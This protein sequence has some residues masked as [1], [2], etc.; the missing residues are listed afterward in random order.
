MANFFDLMGQA[1]YEEILGRDETR[2]E[3]FTLLNAWKFLIEAAMENPR[4]AMGAINVVRKG[5]RY[6]ITQI[7][8]NKKMEPL[9]KNGE[10]LVGR[11]VYA[12]SISDDLVSFMNEKETVIMNLESLKI[13]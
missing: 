3:E 6:K 9:K 1:L 12:Y 5:E 13:A 4:I 7:M 11:I 2:L 8:L 10:F